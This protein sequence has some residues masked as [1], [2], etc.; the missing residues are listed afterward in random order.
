MNATTAL[1][2]VRGLST[3][4]ILKRKVIISW[5][6]VDTA[7]AYQ[8]KLYQQAEDGTWSQIRS[9][10]KVEKRQKTIN[11]LEPDTTY[12]VKVRAKRKSIYGGWSNYLKFTTLSGEEDCTSNQSPEFSADI[13]DLSLVNDIVPPPSFSGVL[14]THSFI[15]TELTRVPVY[16]PMA[17]DLLSGAYYLEGNPGGEYILRFQATCEIQFMFDHMTDP[18]DEI[19]SVFADEPKD[20]TTDEYPTSA[21]SVAAGEL[22]GYTT[23]TQYGIW[24]FGVYNSEAQNDMIFIPLRCA[25]PIMT[26]LLAR[27]N[28]TIP[29]RRI[30]VF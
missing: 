30:F 11:E 17:A 9:I 14:K 15:N 29:E 25:Q 6:K 12:R 22:I 23:G 2:K 19:R 5:K 8:V 10:T 27:Q 20:N 3:E 21:V 24:D 1:N 28:G 26:Y 16:A 7:R 18:K 13:T 4:E